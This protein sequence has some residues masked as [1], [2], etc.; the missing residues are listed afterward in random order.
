LDKELPVE[1]FEKLDTYLD[2]NFLA[3]RRVSLLLL[4]AFASI[5]ILLGML[6]IYAVAANAVTRRQREIAIRLALGATPQRMIAMI[7]RLGIF[8]TLGGIVIGSAIVLALSRLLA[9]VLYGVNAFDAMV[10]SM[11][12]AVLLFLSLIASLIPT[13]R[14][15]RLNIQQILRQ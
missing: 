1:N 8:A 14:L 12:A 9:S 2:N 5:G 13:A 4:S 11:S 7:T 3:G 10:Y 6:G 15:L